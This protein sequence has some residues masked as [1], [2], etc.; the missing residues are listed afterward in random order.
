MR[1][2]QSRG[3]VRPRGARFPCHPPRLRFRFARCTTATAV[4]SPPTLICREGLSRF[5]SARRGCHVTLS[6]VLNPKIIAEYTSVRARDSI[7]NSRPALHK[8]L[9]ASQGTQIEEGGPRV[10]EKKI[11]SPPSFNDRLSLARVPRI[12][13]ARVTI[14]DSQRRLDSEISTCLANTYDGRLRLVIDF[15]RLLFLPTSVSNL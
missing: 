10:E 13:R 6:C 7:T 14:I 3:Q 15:F 4:P 1:T 8:A 12:L 5:F 9:P 11:S 2:S